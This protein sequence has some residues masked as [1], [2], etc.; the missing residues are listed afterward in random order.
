MNIVQFHSSNKNF[1]DAEHINYLLKVHSEDQQQIENLNNTINQLN[2]T[3]KEQQAIIEDL[4][5]QLHKNSENSSYPPSRDL[6]S[7]VKKNRS[8]REKTGNKVGGQPNHPGKTRLLEDNPD[9]VH[10][11]HVHK[12][13][14]G[15]DLSAT[16]IIKYERHQIFEIPVQSYTVIEYR[17]ETKICPDCG[18]VIKSSFPKCASSTINFGDNLKSLIIY[19]KTIFP[20][21]IEK[22]ATIIKDFYQISLSSATIEKIV[23]DAGDSLEQ[24]ET[25]AKEALIKEPVVH[26]DESGFRVISERWWLHT[27]SSNHITLLQPHP[28]RGS[29][30]M[31]D[32]GILPNYFGIAVH[33]YWNGYKKF[34]CKHAFCKAH[35]RRELRGVYE[36]YSEQEWAK[37]MDKLLIDAYETVYCKGIC[38]DD[39]I[40]FYNQISDRYTALVNAGLETNP[41]PE[42]VS[43][44][45]RRKNSKSRN[46]LLR[47][48]KS[49]EEVLSFI[50]NPRIPFTNN[51]AERDLRPL[52]VQQKVSGTFRSQHGAVAYCRITGYLST[53]RKNGRD[54]FEALKLLVKG[55]VI[56]LSKIIG[57]E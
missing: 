56:P 4:K 22:I 49:K 15:T 38:G 42:R 33:D 10:D 55:E 39:A 31:I 27:V 26:F 30:A 6:Y 37:E 41:P 13:S 20:G 14:C 45:G 44:N 11:I 52:K 32:N 47:L 23:N 2:N 34:P 17:G 57:G 36:N 51:L 48:K 35:I 18:K 16:P 9:E 5:A 46:L 24:Y 21:A 8:L 50:L 40:G 12:C 3:I 1:S 53:L 25:E 7:P 54:L 19:L 29:V 43:K 28:V